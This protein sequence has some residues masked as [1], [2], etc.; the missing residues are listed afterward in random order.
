HRDHPVPRVV[1]G[2]EDATT[3]RGRGH[4]GERRLLGGAGLEREAGGEAEAASLLR[5]ALDPDAAAH[6]RHELRRD[7]EAEPGAAAARAARVPRPERIEDRVLLLDGY[8]DAGVGDAPEQHD[9]LVGPGIDGDVND[10]LAAVRELDG[11]PE[12]AREY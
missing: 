8:A 12:E 2:D 7:R 9:V 6:Q 11:V 5:L 4:R 3:G 1:L 10:D